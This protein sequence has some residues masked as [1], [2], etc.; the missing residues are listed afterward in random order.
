MLEEKTQDLM[1]NMQAVLPLTVTKIRTRS[2]SRDSHREK[3]AGG[4]SGRWKDAVKA[5]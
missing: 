3:G 2:L 5:D 4:R 1:V